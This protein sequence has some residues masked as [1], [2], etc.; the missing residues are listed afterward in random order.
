MNALISV[1][2]EIAG[3]FVDDGSLALAVLGTVL[4][5][6]LVAL[7]LPGSLIAAGGVLLVGC[8]AVLLVNVTMAS[9]R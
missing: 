9:R 6:A 4:L 8:L 5:A 1:L 3:L 2:R 7:V